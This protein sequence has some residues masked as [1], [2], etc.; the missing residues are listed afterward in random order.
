MDG[1]RDKNTGE[2]ETPE[3]TDS[4]PARYLCSDRIVLDRV[5]K[6]VRV[7]GEPAVLQ[8]TPFRLLEILMDR[9]QSLVTKEEILDRVW[10]STTVTEASIT[11][12]VRSIRRALGETAPGESI[13]QTVSRRGYSF[14][15]PV[16]ALEDLAAALSDIAYEPDSAPAPAS[17][18]RDYALILLVALIAAAGLGLLTRFAMTPPLQPSGHV[19]LLVEPDVA[20]AIEQR[21]PGFDARL[22]TILA[23]DPVITP[24]TGSPERLLEITR[25][26]SGD[27]DGLVLEI[28]HPGA[29]AN[30]HLVALT[31]G[32]QSGDALAERITMT[33]SFLFR[34]A[35]DLLAV[36]SPA[37][38]RDAHLLSLLYR[39]CD[40]SRSGASA[41]LLEPYSDALLSAFPDED[42]AAAVHALVLASQ[43]E[44][45]L[46]GQADVREASRNARARDL[47]ERAHDGLGATAVF[48]IAQ[49]LL[50]AKEGDA[51]SEE[52]LSLVSAESWLGLRAYLYRVSV[53]R[54]T[55]RLAEAAHLLSTANQIWPGDSTTTANLALTQTMQGQ[56]DEAL[57]TLD[58]ALRVRPDD[59][60][61]K[62]LREVILNLYGNQVGADDTRLQSVPDYL[63]DCVS[64]FLD[65]RRAGAV[66]LPASCDQLDITQRA[67]HQ[68]ILGDIDGALSLIERFDPEVP[69]PRII[70]HYPEFREAWRSQR[71]WNIARTFGLVEYWRRTRTR[72][73]ICYGQ[74]MFGICE[75]EIAQRSP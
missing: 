67:R 50:A 36:M 3:G 73:D 40:A 46:N 47:L 26:P 33:A 17:R 64:G 53:L 23:Q 68:A 75:R 41:R 1:F 21:A 34:C 60:T 2:D 11:S 43:P 56:F 42:G 39:L 15:E 61:L 27:P 5:D 57:T 70:L 63:R 16:R 6:S 28:S 7:D 52:R 31:I 29:G 51:S 37:L 54:Q 13:L 48:E 9:A 4:R 22:Q 18:I 20:G 44:R 74:E 12:A 24:G 30:L 66:S 32:S 69:A 49:T 38:H 65:T 8:P 10:G 58:S 45:H 62:Q 71:M 14:R 59:V 72:P 25:D 19:Q 35:D 55:G